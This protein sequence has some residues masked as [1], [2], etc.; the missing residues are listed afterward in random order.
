LDVSEHAARNTLSRMSRKGWLVARKDGR[1][2]QYSLTPR[3]WSLLVQ[4]EKRIFEPPF[5]EWDGMWHIVVFS[6]PEKKRVGGLR[7]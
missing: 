7:K 3:G 4:G 2:S 5:R 6:L 1:R